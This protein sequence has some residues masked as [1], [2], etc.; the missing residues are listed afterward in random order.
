MRTGPPAARRASRQPHQHCDAVNLRSYLT[1][2]QHKLRS[3]HRLFA[4]K[5]GQSRVKRR[6]VR[7]RRARERRSRSRRAVQQWSQKDRHAILTLLLGE[8]DRLSHDPKHR[9]QMQAPAAGKGR[10]TSGICANLLRSAE[11]E[12]AGRL[13]A[14]LENLKACW[15]LLLSL[16]RA[17]ALL[18]HLGQRLDHAMAAPEA[19]VAFVEHLPSDVRS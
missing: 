6:H 8:L 14:N 11:R 1:D 13:V 9:T 12:Q 18:Q 15:K 5:A 16:A 10:V 2:L 4:A 3:L 19:A 17:G 7:I